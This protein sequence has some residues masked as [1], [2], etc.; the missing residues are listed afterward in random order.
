MSIALLCS[1]LLGLGDS[2]FNTQLYSILG[3]VYA[4]QSAPAFAIFKFIQVIPSRQFPGF[5]VLFCMKHINNKGFEL[6][7]PGVLLQK[8]KNKTF[9][10]PPNPPFVFAAKLVSNNKYT[11]GIECEINSN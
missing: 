1:F 8:G 11:I 2:C 10:T 7:S 4:E 6:N 3:C 5:Q 9:H